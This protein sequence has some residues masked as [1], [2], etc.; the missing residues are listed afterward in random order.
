MGVE[1]K[2]YE[3]SLLGGVEQSS[4]ADSRFSALHASG[5]NT[6][7]GLSFRFLNKASVTEL[8]AAVSFLDLSV[9]GSFPSRVKGWIGNATFSHFLKIVESEE[10]FSYGTGPGLIAMHSS[11]TYEDFINLNQAGE[12]LM[13]LSTAHQ[14][15]YFWGRFGLKNRFILGLAGVVKV[16]YGGAFFENDMNGFQFSTVFRDQ[17][18]QNAVSIE[19]AMNTRHAFGI[20][21]IL[22][23][24]NI[25]E[26]REVRS[27]INRVSFLYSYK[28]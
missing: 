9:N 21:Y 18:F 16:P 14:F 10:G 5:L 2:R 17:W 6:A 11:R 27:L 26:T 28:L 12:Q 25:A 3:I 4:L 19:W 7:A 8:E 22:Q 24:Y 20:T 1:G 23:Y 13:M 15:G